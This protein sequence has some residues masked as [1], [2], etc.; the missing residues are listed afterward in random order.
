MKRLSLMH[1]EVKCKQTI[2]RPRECHSISFH[3][4]NLPAQS[5]KSRLRAANG[6]SNQQLWVR[7]R[8]ANNFVLIRSPLRNA[9]V[10]VCCSSRR[11]ARR[12]CSFSVCTCVW[13]LHANIEN[14]LWEKAARWTTHQ[15]EVSPS[16]AKTSCVDLCN[17]PRKS[18]HSA[19]CLL[20]KNTTHYVK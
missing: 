16:G 2:K 12:K 9:R 5:W 4:S 8:R 3:D 14:S 11:G 18:R 13:R 19:G 17:T 7:P 6:Q 10:C 15:R 20:I 1:S